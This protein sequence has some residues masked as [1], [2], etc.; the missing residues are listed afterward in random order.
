MRDVESHSECASSKI[1]RYSSVR[2]GL[3]EFRAEKKE[4]RMKYPDSRMG[5]K[6]NGR[7]DGKERGLGGQRE[8]S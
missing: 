6:M 7:M 1:V 2:E 4:V 3:D 5:G 8:L